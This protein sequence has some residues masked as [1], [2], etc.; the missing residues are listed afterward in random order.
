MKKYLLYNHNRISFFPDLFQRHADD[1]IVLNR[2][3]RTSRIHNCSTNR[4]YLQC[5]TVT[6]S[7]LIEKSK[8]IYLR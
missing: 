8:E 5:I 6:D 4:Y 3:E 7:Y 2:T 1:A